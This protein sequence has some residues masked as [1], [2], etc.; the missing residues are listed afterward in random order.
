MTQVFTNEE[1]TGY[2][3]R[4]TTEPAN[5]GFKHICRVYKDNEEIKDAE[6]VVTWGNRTWESFKYQTVYSDSQSRLTDVINGVKK[7]EIDT[8][9]L[10][11]LVD[12]YY[13]AD[14]GYMEDGEPIIL[15]DSWSQVEGDKVYNKETNDWELTEPSV[16]A[17]LVKLSKKGLL[18]PSVQTTIENMEYVFTDSWGKCMECGTVCNRDYGELTCLKSECL[19]LCD[20]CI[21]SPDRVQDLINEAQKNYSKALKP[22]VPQET[23]ESLGYSLVTEDTF[24]FRAD[25]WGATFVK[26]AQVEDFMKTFGGF[27]QI[28][29]VAQFVTP[30]QLWVST[31]NLEDAQEYIKAFK[32]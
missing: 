25:F 8:D 19:E 31:E 30:F 14:W 24:S 27:V 32:N 21:N 29:E 22:T 3:F 4:C 20:N 13:I 9:F 17:K 15:M 18:K 2:E 23:I 28:Y 16:Y 6:S 12:N 10:N 5:V 7:P 11:T 26:P 1:F